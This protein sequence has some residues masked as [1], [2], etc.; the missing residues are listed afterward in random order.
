MNVSR[1]LKGLAFEWVDKVV[2]VRPVERS[3]HEQLRL[4][5]ASRRMHL[6]FSPCCADSISVKR[7]CHK[8]GLRVV[9]KDVVR[10]NAYR[11]ELVNGGGDSR[12][13]CLRIEKEGKTDWVYS[14]ESILGYLNQRY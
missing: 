1:Q 13:P 7:H 8:L 5:R 4:D 3:A 6:Y 9:E 11:N 14:L 2:P 10:V 12:I